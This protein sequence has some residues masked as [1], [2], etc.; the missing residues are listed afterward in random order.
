MHPPPSQVLTAEWYGSPFR[1]PFGTAG[2]PDA[3]RVSSATARAVQAVIDRN[4]TKK[5]A[6]RSAPKRKSPTTV[7]EY[8]AR[9]REPAR[10]TLNKLRSTIRSVV[11]PAAAETISYRMPAFRHN[12][13]LVWYA[14]FIDH[15]SLF[16]GAAV[17]EAFKDELVEFTISKGT[18]QFPLDKPLPT[19]L[20][21]RMVK[22]RVAELNAKKLGRRG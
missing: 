3:R 6:G 5:P 15:C 14:A 16:P 18:V 22:A 17:V 4:M 1:R 13:V 21:K 8:V 20:I 12:R 19:A 10:G 7:D 11:P 9:L 2:G